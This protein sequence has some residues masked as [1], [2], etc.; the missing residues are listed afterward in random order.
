[1]PVISAPFRILDLEWQLL[2]GHNMYD[3]DACDYY[4]AM[5]NRRPSNHEVFGLYVME[6]FVAQMV[7]GLGLPSEGNGRKSSRR[8][9]RRVRC[10]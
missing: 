8:F 6:I 2:N 1:V 10:L 5:P 3:V 9:Q 7:P 4:F